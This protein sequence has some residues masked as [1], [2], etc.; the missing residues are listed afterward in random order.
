L[1]QSE[2]T[3]DTLK[4]WQFFTLGG[5]I[6][7]TAAVF[8]MRGTSPANIIF[9]CLGIFAAALVGLGTLR[10]LRPLVTGEVYEPDMIGGQTRV[11]LEREKNLILRSIKELE[12]DYA[13]GKVAAGDY[14]DMVARLRARAVRLLKQLDSAGS[15]YREL[16]EREL[17]Q[18][19]VKTGA[20]ALADTD[21]DTDRSPDTDVSGLRAEGAGLRAQGSGLNVTG[22]NVTGTC[23]TCGTANDGD[24][25]FC[26]GCGTKLLALLFAVL[27]FVTPALAQFQMP[28]PKEMAGIP[29][30]V[31]DL[32]DG[33]VSVRL[34]RG[35]LSNNIQGHPVE[36]HAGGKV[37]TVKTDE[38]GRAEF[39]GVAA[40]TNVK[41]VS[42]VDGE[43]L[44]SQEFPWPGQG[45]IRV[46]LVATI[47]GGAPAP[48]FQPQTGNVAFGDQ[49]RVI[50][51]VAD[52]V[53]QIYYVLDI[54]NGARTPVNPPQALIIDMP[55]GAQGTA[56]LEGGPQ[57]VAIGDRVTVK[58]PFAPGPTPVQVAYQM[59][60]SNGEL[61]LTQTLPVP[62][63][64]VAVLMKKIGDMTLAS[65]Q[66]PALQEREFDGEKY[67]LAQGSALA[68]GS[69][70]TLNISGLPHHSPQPR[71]IALVLALVM[72]GGG[73]WAATR[74]PSPKGNAARVKQLTG[75]REKAFN[76]LVRLELQRRTGSIDA[77]RYAERRQ[78][79]IAQ[80]E[81]VY[82]DLDAERGQGL[83]A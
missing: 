41:A 83:A 20:A 68:A 2:S 16:I 67:I 17:A 26:K 44:E 48:L 58:G 31:S 18:R 80:L 78:T 11:A 30:P 50:L 35:Q 1:P 47:K 37:L 76:E 77:P 53:L 34:I 65:P 4:P 52:D 19:L 14:E 3:A 39:G 43:R 8:V 75:K 70:L 27:T 45:G 81:R 61:S 10:T 63:S 5:L 82:R 57:A 9:A 22:T 62:V 74:A 24:A 71:R 72:L 79:L 55:R 38:N 36:L 40:G 64:S 60:P 73:F 42:V 66:L 25:R 21:I 54:Q 28:D 51:E 32:A 6:C 29:R 7:A 12:F 46:M 23:V 13:M 69:T 49:T 33:R 15:G 56:V 59:L